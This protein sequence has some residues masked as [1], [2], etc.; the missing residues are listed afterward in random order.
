VQLCR[1]LGVELVEVRKDSRARYIL[2][3]GKLRR[4]PLSLKEAANT[5]RHAAFTRAENHAEALT[6]DAWGARH[7]GDGALQYLLTPFVR[8]IYGVQ[9][10]DLGVAA[11]FP[12]LLI[13]KGKTLLGTVIGKSLKRSSTKK[14][15]GHRMVAPKRGMGEIVSRLEEHLDRRLGA[16]FKRDTCLDIL[17]DATNII[18]ATP[19][20]A[21]ADLLTTEYPE[22]RRQLREVQYTPLVSVTVFVSRESLK[23]PVRGVGV[24]I[25]ALEE[26]KCL[27]ILFTSSSF[28]GRVF[29]ES[30]HASFTVLLGGSSQPQ[31][32]S[33]SDSILEEAAR[34][35]LESLLGIMGEPLQSVIS[36][37]PRAIPQYSVALPKLW[38]CAR[39][40]WCAQPG[41]VLFGNYTGQVS[42]RGM[43]ESVV[44]LAK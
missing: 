19:A 24:L 4:F 36:R 16:R 9:P 22:L 33:A 26:R 39:E 12:S 8:G 44:H 3:D 20:A 13:P 18:L 42:L 29:D 21:A 6:L 25:P 28:E 10:T 31:W 43:M 23:K 5:L 30:R 35:E 37:W 32:V 27:G 7:L 11:A 1:E 17:P 41:H 15:S 14:G 38:Q 34:D 2:R 40:T